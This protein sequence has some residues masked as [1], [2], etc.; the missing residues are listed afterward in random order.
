MSSHLQVSHCSFIPPV[1]ASSDA[2]IKTHFR[3]DSWA[4]DHVR[5]TNQG[6]YFDEVDAQTLYLTD[7][8]SATFFFFG[9]FF[10]FKVLFGVL[11]P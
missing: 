7:M 2:S 6:S 9:V 1:M 5:L 10:F 3:G 11:Q 4:F 8:L